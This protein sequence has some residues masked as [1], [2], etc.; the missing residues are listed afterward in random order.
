MTLDDD[1]ARLSRSRPFNLLPREAVQ[2]LAFSCEKRRLKSG[3]KL[4][5]SGDTADCAYFVRSGAILLRE[6]GSEGKSPHRVGAGG[7]IGESALYVST[8]RRVEAQAE[9]D[10]VV[11]GLSRDTFRRVLSEFPSGAAKIRASLAARTRKLVD[12]LEAARVKSLDATPARGAMRD[13][14]TRGPP[15]RAR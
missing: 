7:L 12:N 9:E 5:A 2:L 15:A 14:S 11:L 1:V 10:T 6:V 8:I 13:N 3:D 4:F